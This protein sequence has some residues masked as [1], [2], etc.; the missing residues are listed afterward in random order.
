MCESMGI[1]AIYL[2]NF[3]HMDEIYN[4]GDKDEHRTPRHSG[5]LKGM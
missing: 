2:E 3:L 5:N 4:G 1:S